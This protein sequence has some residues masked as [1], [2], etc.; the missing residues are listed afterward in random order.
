MDFVAR[1]CSTGL[2]QQSENNILVRIKDGQMSFRRRSAD[3]AGMPVEVHVDNI[4]VH[5]IEQP[6]GLGAVTRA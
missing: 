4:A 1:T 2:G 5:G 6:E 3:I